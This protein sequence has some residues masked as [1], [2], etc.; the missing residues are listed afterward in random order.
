MITTVLFGFSSIPIPQLNWCAN[1]RCP[2]P[3]FCLHL[4]VDIATSRNAKID[5]TPCLIPDAGLETKKKQ[6]DSKLIWINY[7]VICFFIS[8]IICVEVDR[9]MTSERRFL[10]TSR[11]RCL[12]I[13]LI[14][15]Y[16]ITIFIPSESRIARDSKKK[17]L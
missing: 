6:R 9:F 11:R 13:R 16:I 4:D 1:G 2:F 8:F 7:P 15:S 5:F 17:L 14:W 10:N 3:L 12:R